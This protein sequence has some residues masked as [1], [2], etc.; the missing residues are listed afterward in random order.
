MLCS[1]VTSKDM[2]THPTEAI[3][4]IRFLNSSPKP[5]PSRVDVEDQGNPDL[6]ED[7]PTSHFSILNK[8]ASG[9]YG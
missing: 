8:V 3:G 4:S 6:I 1:G 5:L 2:D 9:G 7:S